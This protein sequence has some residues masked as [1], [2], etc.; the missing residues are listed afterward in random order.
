MNGKAIT[1][2]G[3]IATAIWLLLIAAYVWAKWS[4][5]LTM[6]PNSLGDFVAGAFGP[7]ALFW[8][9]CGYFQQGLELRQNTEALKL[10]VEELRNSVTHQAQMAEASQQQLQLEMER[11]QEERARD[12]ALRDEAAPKLSVVNVS[13]A[14]S[15]LRESMVDVIA[16]IKNLG[17]DLELLEQVGR[18]L[19]SDVSVQGNLKSLQTIRVRVK[20]IELQEH[21]DSAVVLKLRD[22][23]GRRHEVMLGFKLQHGAYSVELLSLG[24]AT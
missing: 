14:S 15:Y 13:N 17:D 11:L 24:Q 23:L 1:L 12:Q 5:F 9:V 20:A 21:P 7:L 19:V 2:V 18:G 6:E 22:K 16:D 8:L 4:C 10:Q 3:S